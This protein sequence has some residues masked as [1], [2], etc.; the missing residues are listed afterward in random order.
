MIQDSISL[1]KWSNIQFKNFCLLKPIPFDSDQPDLTSDMAPTF[2]R[3]QKSIILEFQKD[4]ISLF[5]VQSLVNTI[6]EIPE[7]QKGFDDLSKIVSTL[8]ENIRGKG[9]GPSLLLQWDAATSALESMTLKD[10]IKALNSTFFFHFPE[11]HQKITILTTQWLNQKNTLK[12]VMDSNIR[13]CSRFNIKK[14]LDD[15]LYENEKKGNITLENVSSK[16]RSLIMQT[17]KNANSKNP[18]KSQN[19]R[20]QNQRSQNFRQNNQ[21]NYQNGRNN[22]QNNP[23]YNNNGNYNQNRG[24]NSRNFQ[25]QSQT[26]QNP[27]NQNQNHQNSYTKT[28]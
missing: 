2:S 26:G 22:R 25:N 4:P 7:G 27:Q 10:Y 15:K 23:R 12:A 17:L 9:F 21:N 8:K 6:N 16:T 1:L 19:Q 18:K 13:S 20:S 24:Q 5:Y 11:L 28:N 14:I 3:N